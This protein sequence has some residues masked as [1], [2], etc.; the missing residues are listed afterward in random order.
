[1]NSGQHIHIHPLCV[2]DLSELVKEN[3]QDNPPMSGR[4][5]SEL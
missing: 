5:K 1:L 4:E 2:M 3:I